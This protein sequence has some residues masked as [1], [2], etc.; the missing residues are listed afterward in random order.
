MDIIR[1]WRTIY[2]WAQPVHAY[3]LRVCVQ[4]T[5]S[6]LPCRSLSCTAFLFPP[7]AGAP[8]RRPWWTIW[9]EPHVASTNAN[10][11]LLRIFENALMKYLW[12]IYT[13]NLEQYAAIMR[14]MEKPLKRFVFCVSE[15]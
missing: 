6:F 4:G 14:Q 10:V 7:G 13:F 11:G 15:F 8:L 9:Q 2:K 5:V 1:D 3:F 12:E